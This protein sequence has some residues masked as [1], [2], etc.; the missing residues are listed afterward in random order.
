MIGK[1]FTELSEGDI[2]FL[3]R[4][5]DPRLMTRIETIKGDPQIIEG[6]LNQESDKLFQRMVLMTETDI[7]TNVS[8]RLFFEVLLRR[9]L[10]ELQSQSYTMERDSRQRIPVFDAP[11]VERLLRQWDDL[12]LVQH[13][14]QVG[15]HV[16]EE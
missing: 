13:R 16:R 1:R 10:R 7:I 14:L 8:P 4:A 5:V 3:V 12:C 11:Q 6:I 2:R 9:A 15:E